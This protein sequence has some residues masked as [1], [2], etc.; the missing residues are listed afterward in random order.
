VDPFTACEGTDRVILRPSGTEPKL[1]AYLQTATRA[2][3][4]TLRARVQGWLAG[5]GA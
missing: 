3:L 1:K 5:A 4:P 2:E